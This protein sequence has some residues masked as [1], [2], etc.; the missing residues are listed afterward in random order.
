MTNEIFST[1]NKS[2]RP[3]KNPVEQISPP[4]WPCR[5]YKN[6]KSRTHLTHALLA[7]ANSKQLEKR[8][9]SMWRSLLRSMGNEIVSLVKCYRMNGLGAS[10][11]VHQ[12]LE[13]V[14]AFLEIQRRSAP[15]S[16]VMTVRGSTRHLED[17][18]M[19]F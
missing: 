12:G 5:Q 13:Q 8:I 6:S 16:T 7:N 19:L 17:A 15:H 18:Y 4:K 1:I 10:V 11:R 2:I 3:Q 14:V 9:R